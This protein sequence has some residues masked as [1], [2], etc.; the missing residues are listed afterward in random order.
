MKNTECTVYTI[1]S[2]SKQY[3]DKSV[4]FTFALKEN[5]TLVTFLL[6][7]EF[8]ANKFE[9]KLLSFLGMERAFTAFEIVL[10]RNYDVDCLKLAN[11]VYVAKNGN[12]KYICNA[13]NDAFIFEYEKAACEQVF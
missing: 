7:E 2:I 5:N 4:L 13:N 3:I 6:A 10:Q 8:D 1:R 9:N 12:A 11:R